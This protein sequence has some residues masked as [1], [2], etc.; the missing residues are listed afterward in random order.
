MNTVEREKKLAEAGEDLTLKKKRSVFV[1][2]YPS[3][4]RTT[5]ESSVS[6]RVEAV[7]GRI[8]NLAP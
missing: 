3:I 1:E 8:R 7:V 5:I 2:T 4:L 6:T